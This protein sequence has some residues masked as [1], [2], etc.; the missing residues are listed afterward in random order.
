MKELLIF[1]KYLVIPFKNDI[2]LNITIMKNN[3]YIYFCR[4]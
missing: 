3:S 1:T 4:L 2:L